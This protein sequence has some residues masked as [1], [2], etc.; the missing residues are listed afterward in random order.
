MEIERSALA[1]VRCAPVPLSVLAM[2]PNAAA[3]ASRGIGILRRCERG[4]PPLAGRCRRH[5]DSARDRQG[6]HVWMPPCPVSTACPTGHRLTLGQ[7]LVT[8]VL[9]P[10]PPSPYRGPA[11]TVSPPPRHHSAWRTPSANRLRF[12]H[13]APPFWP[14]G[15]SMRPSRR[16]SPS[17]GPVELGELADV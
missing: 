16:P 11:A 14:L 8:H 13:F 5:C 10:G 6:S 15:A 4:I 2:S 3:K 1:V 7:P 9:P 17:A 12:S